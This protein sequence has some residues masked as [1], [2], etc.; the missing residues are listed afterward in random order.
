M[1]TRW[2]RTPIQLLEQQV[3]DLTAQ[4]EQ[5]RKPND[6]ATMRDM[7]N[8]AGIKYSE[9]TYM[10]NKIKA[11]K[12]RDS[13]LVIEEDIDRDWSLTIWFDSKGQLKDLV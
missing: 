10:D 11:K 9:D 3:R 5:A 7:L 1:S 4:L 2:D 12:N 13:Y 6:L 8:R